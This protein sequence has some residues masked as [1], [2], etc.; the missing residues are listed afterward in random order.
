MTKSFTTLIKHANMVVNK[1]FDVQKGDNVLIIGDAE[2]MMEAQALSG[3]A[4]QK[5]AHVLLADVTPYV[6]RCLYNMKESMAPAANLAGAMENSDVI[7]ITTNIEWANRFAHVDPV[8]IAC[9]KGAKVA[10]V[11]YGMGEWALNE[12]DI[13][14]IVDRTV[15]IGKVM[16]GGKVIHVFDDNGTDVKL[17]IAGRPPLLV[18]P[19]KLA[20]EMMGPLPLW[21]EVAWAA[22]EDDT[23]GIIVFDG[24][25]LGVGVPGTLENK[26]R[27]TMEKGRAV[28][29]E[30]GE[31][32]AKLAQ[33]VK[34]NANANIIGEFALGISEFA[35][36]GN[37]SEK[38]RL[39]VVHM[40]LGDN[41]HCYPG[42]QN[43]SNVHLDGSIRQATVTVDGKK[44]FD[45]GV[46]VV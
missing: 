43:H 23:E 3:C 45:K 41:H 42:G 32:A 10:S 37:A 6:N 40:A 2:H 29:F 20:G 24:I 19:I 36:L 18:K 39:G 4:T 28:K 12:D 8:G 26:I 27:I 5:G 46:L 7:M 34:D 14:E 38:G 11:E 35:P 13:D 44:I 1:C 15:R 25:M 30:G 33:V 9:N 16:E 17:S 31:E 21:G 22:K